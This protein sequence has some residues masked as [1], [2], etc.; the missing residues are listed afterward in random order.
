MVE[1]CDGNAKP[2]T[3]LIT[4][5]GTGPSWAAI[6]VRLDAGARQAPCDQRRGGD[7]NEVVVRRRISLSADGA[8][9]EAWG[10]LQSNAAGALSPKFAGLRGG[11]QWLYP[12][13][14]LSNRSGRWA[15]RSECERQYIVVRM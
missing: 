2:L 7:G 4:L 14:Y 10:R 12:T 15:T 8:V 6:A 11:F 1:E 3:S 9:P 13:R 5:I